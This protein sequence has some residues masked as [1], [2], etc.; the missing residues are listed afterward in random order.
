[1]I[2]PLKDRLLVKRD[3]TQTETEGGL[4]IAEVAQR[5]ETSGIVFAIG[6]DVT[7]VKVSDRILFGRID[8]VDIK[9]EYVGEDGDFIMLRE[10]QIKAIYV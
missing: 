8:G 4:I 7:E 2:K 3:E 9:N 6:S 10:D 1:M 5:K